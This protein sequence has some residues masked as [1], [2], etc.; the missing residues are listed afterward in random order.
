MEHQVLA[1]ALSAVLAFG[2]GVVATFLYLRYADRRSEGLA[3]AR[4]QDRL[5]C[6]SNEYLRAAIEAVPAGLAFFDAGDRYV[7]WNSEYARYVREHAGEISVGEPF[8]SIV[9]RALAAGR[10]P[11]AAGR[12]E[13]WISERLLLHT[14][15]DASLEQYVGS[16]R[17][18]RIE[19]RAIAQG[20]RVCSIVDITDLKRR[21]FRDPLTGLPNRAAF[22]AG[23]EAQQARA[24]A[25]GKSF[26]VVCIDLD[27][28]KEVNDVFGHAVGD[29][30]LKQVGTR[31]ARASEGHFLARPGG[32]ELN[33]IISGRQ[34]ETGREICERVTAAMAADF[35]VGEHRLEMSIS[36][37]VAVFPRDGRDLETLLANADAALYQVKAAG[38]GAVHFFDA[39]TD[40]RLRQKRTLQAELKAGIERGE[41][42]VQYQPKAQMSGE[43]VGF[44]ALVRWRHP[45]RNL[46]LPDEFIPLAEERGLI[47]A[48]G[49]RVLREAC[50]EAAGWSNQVSIAVNLSPLQFRRGDLANMV[51]SILLETGLNPR[52]LELEI[53]EGALVNNFNRA[54]VIL[55]QLKNIGVKI[56]ID[57]FG[58]GY[59]SLGYLHALPLDTVKIDRQFVAGVPSN[60]QSTA[61]VRSIIGL[62]RSLSVSVIAEGVETKSQ[63]R[64]L[65][66]E[67]CDQIQGFALGPPAPI[68]RYAAIVGNGLTG[69]KSATG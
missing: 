5:A 33:L 57:D 66:K 4:P 56:A 35:I 42:R 17:W 38:R 13:E 23:L 58:T 31:L 27:H 63:W 68:A 14:R 15:A 54:L 55:G 30:L 62:A 53:T 6:E 1:V 59:S 61:I 65:A 34:P 8:E 32:D 19:E 39:D 69:L 9:R 28:F 10:F 40:R 51:H 12:E 25:D 24:A 44:E 21:E 36:A 67:G 20:G 29:E 16:D 48:L 43:I 26:A 22:T 47:F 52:R 46:I 60:P 45:H 2:A 41:L 50:R 7:V 3:A 18:L 37:G 11:E 64:F 49:E